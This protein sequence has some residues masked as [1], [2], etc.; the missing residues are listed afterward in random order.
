M[1]TRAWLPFVCWIMDAT[2]ETTPRVA[3]LASP[4][5]TDR[6]RPVRPAARPPV[7]WWRL[8]AAPGVALLLAVVARGW[9]R[10]LSTEPEF[11]WSGTIIILVAFIFSGL[12]H[13]VAAISRRGRRRWST[14][15]RVVGALLVLPLFGGA[16]AIMLPTVVAGSLA[17]W[18]R[19]WPLP[20]RLPIA[21]LALPA[22][23]FVT[24]DAFDGGPGLPELV[25]LVL[26]AVTY[27]VV[28]WAMWPIAAPIDDGW[29]L[30]RWVRAFLIGSTVLAT[31]ALLAGIT[32]IHG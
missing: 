30:D 6:S 9:M 13:A 1:V 16:G 7:R 18:R 21:A 23:A 22:P 3:T 17:V 31:T 10:L 4:L 12:G 26:F 19:D 29:R 11:S 8:G 32:G 5:P 28:I 24:V 15:G 25:G 14:P 20:L 2:I 27:A